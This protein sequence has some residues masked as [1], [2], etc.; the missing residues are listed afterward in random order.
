MMKRLLR[1]C[2]SVILIFAVS[3]P[4][5]Q[6]DTCRL[7]ISL[8]T[9]SPGTELYSTFG[10]SAIRVTDLAAG[11]D[12]VYNY[13]TFDFY[14]PMFLMKFT[15]G[16]LL[17]YLDQQSFSGFMNDYRAENRSV[18]EQILNLNCEE[19]TELQ[20]A[21]FV[22]IRDENKFY[23]YDFLFDNCT[24]RIRDLIL[25]QKG[26]QYQTAN[27]LPATGFTFRNHI[28]HY[29]DNNKQF[30]SKLGID[31]LLG[32]KMDRAMT[33]DEAMFLPDY[34][35]KGFD[36]SSSRNQHLVLT[37]KVLFEKQEL[38]SEG[39]AIT[40]SFVFWALA[41]LIGLATFFLR[42]N[43][44]LLT[45]IDFFIFFFNGLLGCFLVFMWFGTDH[46]TTQN[47]LNLLWAIPTHIIAAFFIRNK[48]SASKLYFQVT[49]VLCALLLL[50]WAFLPQ[51][52]NKALFPWVL[53][54]GIRSFS[55]FRSRT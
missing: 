3:K 48:N 55:I 32:K 51:E 22:N 14:D 18:S 16:Q 39:F 10:H 13:G 42:P 45:A 53:L 23:Q 21:L 37:K 15:R 46:N 49:T 27:V 31:I 2:L 34:L 6:T 29:L 9:C 47:N 28:H 1:L 19:K 12:I 11:T 24:T 7:K 54:T 44:K 26:M 52:L 43:S 30:W 40:P 8:L 38:A 33:N 25:K 17:Y 41:I 36:S 4:F 20:K 50:S 5:A 35:E